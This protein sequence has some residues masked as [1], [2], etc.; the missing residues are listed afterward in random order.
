MHRPLIFLALLTACSGG[1]DSSDDTSSASGQHH[2][3]GYDAP[4]VHGL[5]A[6]LSEEACVACHAADLTGDG[7]AVSCDNCHAVGWRTDCT[8]CHGGEV[9]S[10]GAPPLDI[11]GS[12][13]DLSFAPHTAHVN[14]GLHAAYDCDQCH[15]KPVDALSDG[16]LFSGDSTPAVAELDFG[17]GLSTSATWDGAGSCSNLYCHGSGRGDD[18][19]AAVGDDYSACSSCHPDDTSRDLWIS[20]S[21]EHR[22]HLG[23]NVACD[24]CHGDTVSDMAIIDISLHVNGQPDLK[25]EDGMTWTD[26]TCNGTCHTE[27]HTNRH[28]N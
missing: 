11:D 17:G 15:T 1:K 12:S 5:A 9:D 20:M 26:G 23:H 7:D 28:W 6:K 14:D 22:E 8:F 3:D 21:G 24:G 19:E 27:V 13:S 4:E 2:P 10:T 18:G 25:L 16:H